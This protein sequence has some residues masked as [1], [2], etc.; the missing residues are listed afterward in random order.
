MNNLKVKKIFISVFMI[1]LLLIFITQLM[2]N[3]T[4]IKQESE[5]IKIKKE[6]ILEK[7]NKK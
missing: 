2:D 3:I 5:N 7:M 1:M 6:I 4:K